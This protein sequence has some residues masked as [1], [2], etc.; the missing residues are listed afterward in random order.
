MLSKYVKLLPKKNL[1]LKALAV[2]ALGEQCPLS[3]QGMTLQIRPSGSSL[4]YCI[5][6]ESVLISN[7]KDDK[8]YMFFN[9]KNVN[10]RK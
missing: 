2:F 3:V 1:S 5:F 6:L 10:K 4:T 7:D 9:N 8:K